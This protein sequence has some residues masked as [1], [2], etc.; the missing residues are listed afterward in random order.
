M[1][2][3]LGYDNVLLPSNQAAVIS[4]MN[5]LWLYNYCYYFTKSLYFYY[6]LLIIQVFSQVEISSEELKREN[7]ASTIDGLKIEVSGCRIENDA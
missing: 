1:G 6:E 7:G 4:R 2:P 5:N 3:P